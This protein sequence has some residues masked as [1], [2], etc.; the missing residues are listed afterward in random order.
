L[1]PTE[2]AVAAKDEPPECKCG[3]VE[4]IA[5]DSDLPDP[6][7]PSLSGFG[8][9]QRQTDQGRVVWTATI[10]TT[11]Y[12]CESLREIQVTQSQQQRLVKALYKQARSRFRT[13]AVVRTVKILGRTV[14]YI[15]FTYPPWR[16]WNRIETQTDEAELLRKRG[17]VWCATTGIGC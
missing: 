1:R 16:A 15:G 5:H 8:V 14:S 3:C 7:Y 6:G 11:R 13:V 17:L 9:W 2:Y 4:W 10:K 12:E